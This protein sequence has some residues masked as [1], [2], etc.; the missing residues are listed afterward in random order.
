M[1][2]VDTSAWIEWLLGSPV[3]DA[4]EPYMPEQSDWLVPTMVQLELQKW[5]DREIVD[6][7]ADQ[8][9]A[10]TQLCH[11][12]PL[13]TERALL[14]AELCRSHQLATAD[15]VIL[16][17]A[18]RHGCPGSNV[19]CPFQGHCGCRFL[20]KASLSTLSLFSYIPHMDQG[21]LDRVTCA[22]SSSS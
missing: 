9:I 17:K 21:K 18:Q 22:H 16:A 20:R 13:D 2:L 7:K 19:R 6:D 11:V 15:S 8:I 3:G 12:A 10:F 1:I 14:A 5:L 4:M